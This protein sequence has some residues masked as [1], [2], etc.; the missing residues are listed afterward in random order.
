MTKI[1]MYSVHNCYRV[2]RK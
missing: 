1:N 2:V